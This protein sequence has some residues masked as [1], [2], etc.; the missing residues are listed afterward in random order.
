M[1][2][3]GLSSAPRAMRNSTGVMQE[4][5]RRRC[6][7][8]GVGGKR[9]SACPPLCHPHLGDHITNR[10]FSERSFSRGTQW[11]LLAINKAVWKQRDILK[12]NQRRWLAWPSSC[13]VCWNQIREWGLAGKVA[14]PQGC[15]TWQISLLLA[16]VV[17]WFHL[18][19]GGKTK[20]FLHVSAA[21][22]ILYTR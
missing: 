13:P 16:P 9:I 5:H 2:G 21:S 3:G 18:Q 17:D 19:M 22:L 8:P 12:K 10:A 1:V 6:W 20:T 11:G 14:R 4:N 7:R 15:S